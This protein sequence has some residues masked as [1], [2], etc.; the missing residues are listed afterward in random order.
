MKV[1]RFKRRNAKATYVVS[2]SKDTKEK[3]QSHQGVKEVKVPMVNAK[4]TIASM[5]IKTNEEKKKKNSKATC[6]H[7]NQGAFHVGPIT[8]SQLDFL[9]LVTMTSLQMGFID[10]YLLKIK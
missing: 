7:K 1:Q 9:G 3:S 6:G 10:Q 5:K 2:K 4:V 8:W